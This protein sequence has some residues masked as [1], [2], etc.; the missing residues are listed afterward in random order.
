MH[1]QHRKIAPGITLFVQ[2]GHDESAVCIRYPLAPFAGDG[3][4]VERN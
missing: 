3:F 2:E 4:Q 1:I